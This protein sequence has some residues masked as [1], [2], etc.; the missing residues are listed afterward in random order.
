MGL[1]EEQS[2][3]LKYFCTAPIY[4]GRNSKWATNRIC[5]FAILR[6]NQRLFCNKLLIFK[7]FNSELCI[8][9]TFTESDY[10]VGFCENVK[11]IVKRM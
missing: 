9:K 10:S 11:E 7:F 4:R 8:L 2:M 3:Y 6:I 1:G 5:L